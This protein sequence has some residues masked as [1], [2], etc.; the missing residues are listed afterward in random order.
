MTTKKNATPTP[1]KA[2][3]E[4]T[5]KAK[6]KPKT[7]A[8]I[9]SKEKTRNATSPV[10][11][12]YFANS[13]LKLSLKDRALLEEVARRSDKGEQPATTAE[14]A[15]AAGFTTNQAAGAASVL[16]AKGAIVTRRERREGA[17]GVFR[18]WRLTEAGRKSFDTAEE[19]DAK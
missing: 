10:R 6:A 12:A 9:A 17:P 11:Q 16:Q 1:A 3:A 4:A 5:T 15:L 8:T 18:V 19:A 13:A 7:P 14:V 2:K